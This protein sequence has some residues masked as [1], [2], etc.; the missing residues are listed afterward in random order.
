MHYERALKIWGA[1]KLAESNKGVTEI[2]LNSVKVEMD[3]DEGFSCCGGRDP[4][5]YC[6]Y[7]QSPSAN[8]VVTGKGT[9]TGGKSIEVRYTIDADS[10][11]FV[12]ILKE[13][14]DI[15]EGK[16]SSEP[17]IHETKFVWP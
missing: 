10:F 16:I 2:L 1:K 5:C 14:V 15:G 12:E 6:S 8:V 4:G 13:L 17:S 7:A 9:T 11:N 3:F